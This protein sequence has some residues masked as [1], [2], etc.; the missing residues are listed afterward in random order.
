[1]QYAFDLETTHWVRVPLRFPDDEGADVF[2]W[3]GRV[4][5]ALAR[6]DERLHAAL[7][8]RA[9]ELATVGGPREG[10]AERLWL[11]PSPTEPEAVAHLYFADAQ[12]AGAE[13][14]AL[15]GTD[16]GVQSM[17]AVEGTGFDEALAVEILMQT[18]AG[19]LIV[20][21]RIGRQGA[22]IAILETIDAAPSPASLERGPLDQL[23]QGLV[24]RP[25]A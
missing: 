13:D 16:G 18:D 3:A 1:M 10:A 17:R 21:R 6:G 2:G 22:T 24:V 7:R 11:L 14:F 19:V 8:G 25:D 15:A 5:D 4:A 12:G 20:S 23:L 9:T